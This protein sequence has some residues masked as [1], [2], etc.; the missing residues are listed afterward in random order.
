MFPESTGVIQ[1]Q[2]RRLDTA[3]PAPAGCDPAAG[4]LLAAAEVQRSQAE[5]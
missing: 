1:E 5:S 4:S 2:L 3:A